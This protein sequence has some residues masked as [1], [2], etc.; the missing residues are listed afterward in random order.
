MCIHDSGVMCWMEILIWLFVCECGLYEGVCDC[1]LVMGGN[2]EVQYVI[3]GIMKE[4]VN[5]GL[6]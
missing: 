6:V 3:V 4:Y 5:V 2:N 1:G